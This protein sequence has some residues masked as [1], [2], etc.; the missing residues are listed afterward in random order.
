MTIQFDTLVLAGGS[1]KGLVVLGALQY[2]FEQ[3]FFNNIDT[4]IGTSSGAV[5]CFLLSIGYTPTEIIVYLCVNRFFEK[6]VHFNIV[7][8]INDNGAITFAG[9]Q[10]VLEKMT[11]SKI[12]R[13]P[14]LKEVYEKYNKTL[15]ITTYNLSKQQVEYLSHE[16]S[17][18]LPCLVALRMSCNLPLIFERFNY[19]NNFYIDGGLVDNFPIDLAYKM[20]K[21]SLGILIDNT[22]EQNVTKYKNIVEYIYVLLSIPSKKYLEEKIKNKPENSFVVE[23]DCGNISNFDFSIDNIKKLDLFSTGYTQMKTELEKYFN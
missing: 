18:D 2:A 20:G 8:M 16:N 5:L 21:K 4:Y 15:I 12:G 1:G 14:T 23:L 7:N 13:L 22:L 10:E 19:N 9:F 11:V 17:P 6:V 3:N